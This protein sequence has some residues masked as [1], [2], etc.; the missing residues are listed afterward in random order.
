[1]FLPFFNINLP[2]GGYF[3][4]VGTTIT[5]LTIVAGATVEDARDEERIS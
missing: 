4:S 1:M 2:V 5:L 3:W